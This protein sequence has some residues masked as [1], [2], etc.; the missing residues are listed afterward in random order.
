MGKTNKLT[1]LI[2]DAV[3]K[4]ENTGTEDIA[5]LESLQPLLD[6]I[7]KNV[8]ELTALPP[9]LRTQTAQAAA[10]AAELIQRMLA[11]QVSDV[12]ESF[13]DINETVRT[14]QSII[15]QIDS[16]VELPGVEPEQA[17]P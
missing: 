13:N 15:Q 5:S 6:D 1:Q 3:L 7:S 4:V 9:E 11:D 8:E 16:V 2:S 10:S 12:Q 17:Q 14:L